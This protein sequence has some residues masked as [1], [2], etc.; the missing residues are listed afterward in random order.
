MP[1]IMYMHVWAIPTYR[2][3]QLYDILQQ[4]T[5]AIFIDFLCIMHAEINT[6]EDSSQKDPQQES[7]EEKHLMAIENAIQERG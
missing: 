2:V 1:F 6:F 3:Y 7:L 5:L 4:E